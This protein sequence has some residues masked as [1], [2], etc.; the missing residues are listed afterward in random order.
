MAE[1][2][3]ELRLPSSGAPHEV[4]SLFVLLSHSWRLET[5]Q[6]IRT[7]RHVNSLVMWKMSSEET[8]AQVMMAG[9]PVE[10]G[11]ISRHGWYHVL[12]CTFSLI[13]LGPE[14]VGVFER[15]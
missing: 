11:V 8:V 3:S 5:P 14:L 15:S 9:H 1:S 4:I 2:E 12:S 13:T 10:D 7:D 6:Y